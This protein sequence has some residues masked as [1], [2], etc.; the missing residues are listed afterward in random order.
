MIRPGELRCRFLNDFPASANPGLPH[1]VLVPVFNF[2]IDVVDFSRSAPEA[3]VERLENL[4]IC[5]I[6]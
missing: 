5:Q 1:G 3:L 2:K 4:N 6:L